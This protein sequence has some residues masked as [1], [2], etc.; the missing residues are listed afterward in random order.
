MNEQSVN[1][2]PFDNG[3]T[4]T[5]LF[6]M[7]DTESSNLQTPVKEPVPQQLESETQQPVQNIEVATRIPKSQQTPI[8]T[9]QQA[10]Q[11]PAQQEQPVAP[12]QPQQPVGQ[13]LQAHTDGST[14][15][16]MVILMN[17]KEYYTDQE[18]KQK[19]TLYGMECSKISSNVSSLTS[20]D[21]TVNAGRIDTL[22]TPV[23]LDYAN[24]QAKLAVTELQ[25]KY[26]EQKAFKDIYDDINSKKLNMPSIDDRK[27]MAT[28]EIAKL[29]MKEDNLNL[30]ELKQRYT[31]RAIEIESIVKILQ[32]KKDLLITYSAALKIENTANNFTASVPTD[33]QF[34]QM[35]S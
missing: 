31:A 11:Q 14:E 28:A 8:Q 13:P 20:S 21:I 33:K 27:A 18:W 34:N 30:Y 3:N 25:L 16:N 15:Q 4:D 35:R 5:S 17:I 12:P 22:L 7:F 23:R 24:I 10:P 6:D 2:S 9:V 1:N 19:Y 29:K 26:A 32:D